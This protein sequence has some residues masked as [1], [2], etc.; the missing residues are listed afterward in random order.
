[1]GLGPWVSVMAR[2]QGIGLTPIGVCGKGIR[3]G[4]GV[5]G[6]GDLPK[7]TTLLAP[8]GNGGTAP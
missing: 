2:S 8:W 6:R 1:M 7:I 3:K 4:V 5:C